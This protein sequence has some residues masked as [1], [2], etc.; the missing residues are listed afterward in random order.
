MR[1]IDEAGWVESVG[2]RHMSNQ[3]VLRSEGRERPG[4][5]GFGQGRRRERWLIDLD[6]QRM[7]RSDLEGCDGGWKT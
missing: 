2:Q 5:P 1:W 4:L 3:P 7:T 6:E